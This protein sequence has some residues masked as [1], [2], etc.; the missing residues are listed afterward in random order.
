MD[1]YFTYYEMHIPSFR[2]HSPH[3]LALALLSN[4]TS[5]TLPSVSMLQSPWP[6]HSLSHIYLPHFSGSALLACDRQLPVCYSQVPHTGAL[7][8]TFI[9]HRSGNPSSCC[10]REAEWFPAVD[11]IYTADCSFYSVLTGIEEK[12]ESEG[13][14][15]VRK[16]EKGEEAEVGRARREQGFILLLGH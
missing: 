1:I 6:F 9:S 3:E 16:R 7:K 11:S 15:E 14:K 8:H 5:C 12:R 13:E 4:L 10:L 2:G